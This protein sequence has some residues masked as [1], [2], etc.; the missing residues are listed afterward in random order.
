M[1]I[2][3]LGPLIAIYILFAI[4]IILFYRLQLRQSGKKY[5]GLLQ[6]LNLVKTKL[7]E[8]Q[9][10]YNQQAT[11]MNMHKNNFNELFLKSM[12]SIFFLDNNKI[13]DCNQKTLDIFE[14]KTKESLL[15][16]YPSNLSLEQASFD[17]MLAQ[18][19][20][21][22]I[23]TFEWKF[24]RQTGKDFLADVVLFPINYNDQQI[25]C[26]M[27]QDKSTELALHE[28]IQ[29]MQMQVSQTSKLAQ[30]G[31][32]AGI[33]ANELSTQLS[34][35]SGFGQL[36]TKSDQVDRQIIDF[37]DK[38]VVASKKMSITIDHLKQFVTSA[39]KKK[40]KQ[41]NVNEAIV[42]AIM[43][44]DSSLHSS[45]VQVIHKLND[46]LPAI[47][48]D[49]NQLEIVFQSLVMMSYDL[50]FKKLPPNSSDLSKLKLNILSFECTGGVKVIYEAAVGSNAEVSSELENN[51]EYEHIKEIL[52]EHKGLM[53]IPEK[54]SQGIKIELFLPIDRRRKKERLK[55]ENI[56]LVQT[57]QKEAGTVSKKSILIVNHEEVITDILKEILGSYELKIITDGNVV[58]E[59]IQNNFFDLII[60]SFKM[61]IVSGLDVL[62]TCNSLNLKTPILFIDEGSKDPQEMQNAL[63]NG[64]KEIIKRPF[65]DIEYIKKTV[66]KYL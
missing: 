31:I 35:I 44:C 55:N 21:K 62:F 40:W 52:D 24:I 30:V 13:I 28:K 36:I 47:W 8:S 15:F 16:L 54:E 11:S 64:A 41:I 50:F 48:G 22:G 46:E 3:I 45:N 56:E 6:E 2:T 37:A 19:I 42:N 10:S 5:N 29:Q 60:T 59:T 38:I 65:T 4:L 27:V 49:M 63:T 20:N 32:V 66:E 39:T 17:D 9:N 61:P 33:S 43:I 18:A 23:H 26:C 57:L 12:N 51:L 25:F 1:S 7:G 34:A 58:I 53:E 14:Y